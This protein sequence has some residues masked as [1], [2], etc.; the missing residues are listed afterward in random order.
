[1]Y[2]DVHALYN[3]TVLFEFAQRPQKSLFAPPNMYR[4]AM[5]I[6][7]GIFRSADD[8]FYRAGLKYLRPTYFHFKNVWVR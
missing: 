5:K 7:S 4:L 2:R 3:F 6:P 1:M 8:A